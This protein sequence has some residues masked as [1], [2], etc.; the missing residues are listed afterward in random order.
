MSTLLLETLFATQPLDVSAI[1]AR[2]ATDP[3][4]VTR[5]VIANAPA[6]S[7]LLSNVAYSDL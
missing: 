4:A 6:L 1:K 2:L 7:L 5:F 3:V